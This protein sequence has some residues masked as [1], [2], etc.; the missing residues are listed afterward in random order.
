MNTQKKLKTYNFHGLICFVNEDI[1]EGRA[2]IEHP[3]D[4]VTLPH[5]QVIQFD[6]FH[7]LLC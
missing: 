4:I 1:Q 3:H 6:S 7:C 2:H 5:T